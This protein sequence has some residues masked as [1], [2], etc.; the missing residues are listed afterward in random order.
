LDEAEDEEFDVV[1]FF[2]ASTSA[3]DFLLSFAKALA[4]SACASA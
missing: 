3:I 4:A 1:K 2:E